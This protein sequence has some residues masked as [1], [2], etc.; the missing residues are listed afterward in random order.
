MTVERFHPDH[1]RE[2]D[3]QPAQ[4]DTAAAFDDAEYMTAL[5]SGLAGTLRD[6]SG[7]VVACA[8]VVE[9]DDGSIGWAFLSRDAGRHMVAVVRMARRIMETAAMPIL[10]SAACSF[11]QGCRMLEILGFERQPEPV[12]GVSLQAGPHYLYVRSA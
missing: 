5:C 4:R 9:V 11:P 8:G 7:A 1:L 10:S 12:E 6:A 3:L 2:I